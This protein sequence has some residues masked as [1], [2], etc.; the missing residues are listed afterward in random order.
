MSTAT[1]THYQS[2]LHRMLYRKLQWLA[3]YGDADHRPAELACHRFADLIVHTS[4]GCPD[5]YLVH[6]H[7]ATLASCMTPEASLDNPQAFTETLGTLFNNARDI[8]I[9]L[10]YSDPIRTLPSDHP[11]FQWEGLT[12]QPQ[13]PAAIDIDALTQPLDLPSPPQPQRTGSKPWLVLLTVSA[14][15]SLAMVFI[16]I[17]LRQ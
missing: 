2:L 5:E 15:F 10:F 4:A 8:Y 1:L 3:Y 6:L 12:N 7:D 9:A 11:R 16:M 14:F 17:G 13:D